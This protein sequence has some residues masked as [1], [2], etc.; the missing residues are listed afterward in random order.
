MG[1]TAIGACRAKGFH[2]HDNSSLL[3]KVCDHVDLV[4]DQPRAFTVVDQ[5]CI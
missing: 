5:R 3:Y 1:L 4:Y 2:L